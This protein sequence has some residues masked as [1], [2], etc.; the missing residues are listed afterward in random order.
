[1]F[2]STEPVESATIDENGNYV[3]LSS[4]ST[5]LAGGDGGNRRLIGQFQEGDS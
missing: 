5:T 2:Q 1:M 3:Q 4:G